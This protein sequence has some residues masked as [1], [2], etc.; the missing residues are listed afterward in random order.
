MA[1]YGKSKVLSV[2]FDEPLLEGVRARAK[3]HGRSVSGEVVFLVRERL[4][5]D[6]RESTRKVYPITG[7]LSRRQ[8]DS[9]EADAFAKARADVRRQ[10]E[11]SIRN[12]AK[13]S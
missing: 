10:L 2:R 6:R 13:R 1:L 4:G 5:E 7:W 3:R 8:L 9:L 11:R 12:K